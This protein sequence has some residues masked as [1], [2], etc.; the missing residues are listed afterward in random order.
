VRNKNNALHGYA[1][2]S[3]AETRTTSATPQPQSKQETLAAE[4]QLNKNLATENTLPDKA[5]THNCQ[6]ARLRLK[7][8]QLLFHAQAKAHK[9]EV[10]PKNSPARY[11]WRFS[12]VFI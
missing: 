7:C 6:D 1:L 3:A 2:H 10:T 4:T 5:L 9:V 11:A 12:T 8:L